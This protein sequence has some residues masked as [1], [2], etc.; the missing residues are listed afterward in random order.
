MLANLGALLALL[1]AA[2]LVWD[3]IAAIRRWRGL[4]LT[5]FSPRRTF[6]IATL[7]SLLYVAALWFSA[8]PPRAAAWS[9][10]ALPVVMILVLARGRGVEPQAWSSAGTWE[11]HRTTRVDIPA[12]DGQIPA[13]LF[14]PAAGGD[15]AVLVLHGA[16][17]HKTFYSWPLIDG[18]LEAG[19]AVCA[20]DIDGH[21]DNARVLEFPAVLEDVAAP[22]CWLRERWEFVGVVG[23]SLG[24]CIAAR[25]VAE[26]VAVD[27]LALLEAPIDARVSRRARRNERWTVARRAT[28]ELHRY[29]GTVPLITGWRTAPTRTRIG[30]LDL[31][32]RLDLPGSVGRAVCPLLLV[33]GG[34]DLVV[35]VEQAH[36]VAVVAPAGTPLH[37]VPGATHLS[38]P[39]DVRAIRI[40]AEWL[41]G[42][43]GY[44]V[45]RD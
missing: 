16:G 29:A 15:A 8:D 30:T 27:A 23:V 39:I 40:T 36:T 20:I 22:V 28:W 10:L 12:D 24:G 19:L 3:G 33:Y 17:A 11:A 34:D 41:R 14:E 2:A 18:L 44:G 38:L 43:V 6:A 4:R 9:A 35:P 37:I 5:A 45:L 42:F 13:L 21:G 1:V 32:R 26:G 25:A 31:I 7:V